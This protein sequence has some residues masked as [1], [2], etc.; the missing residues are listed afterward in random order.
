MKT[1]LTFAEPDFYQKNLRNLRKNT[2]A[3]MVKYQQA[4]RA[5]GIFKSLQQ[6][7]AGSDERIAKKEVTLRTH[8]LPACP[9]ST[10]TE[11]QQAAIDHQWNG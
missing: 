6:I 8:L 11:E 4:L 1:L 10:L 2:D 3:A 7:R 9:E 5:I